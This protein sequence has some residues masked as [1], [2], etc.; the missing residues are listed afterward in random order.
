MAPGNPAQEIR[1]AAIAHVVPSLRYICCGD[2]GASTLWL[3]EKP[4]DVIGDSFDEPSGRAGGVWVRAPR[5]AIL[6]NDMDQFVNDR[7]LR[8]APQI[9]PKPVGT[10]L[11]LHSASRGHSPH[12]L[13][14]RNTE[15]LR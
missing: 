5:S 14:Q 2:L 9:A 4:S 7:A 12:S 10:T 8:F 15:R 11:D 1:A 3:V 13:T 6:L